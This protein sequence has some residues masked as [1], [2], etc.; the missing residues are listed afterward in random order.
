[1]TADLDRFRANRGSRLARI[2]PRGSA[3]STWMTL[4]HPL[5]CAIEGT[6][7]F[8][9]LLSDISENAEL[10][11]RHIKDELTENPAI[12]GAYP[13]ACGEGPRWRENE[14]RLRNGVLIQARGRGSNIRG[15][16]QRSARPTLI[17]IDDPQDTPD[18]VSQTE[19][20]RAWEW[21]TRS[22]IPAGEAD[23]TSFLSVGTA[24]HREAIAYRL[25]TTP[26][27]D[28]KVYRSVQSWPARSD[29]WDEWGRKLT[30]FTD[31]GRN[32]TARAFYE[33]N[34]AEMDRGARVLWP[35]GRDL[36]TLMVRRAEIGPSAFDT[37]DQGNPSSGE[38]AVWP[39][40]YFDYP[41]F[42]FDEWPQ[43]L[44]LRVAWYDP[45]GSPGKRAGCYHAL[46]LCGTDP[47]GVLW[48][49][50]HLW[51]GPPSEAVAG[52]DAECRRFNPAVIG[53][54]GNFGGQF[55]VPLFAALYEQQTRGLR[56]EQFPPS[57]P[58]RGIDNTDPKTTRIRWIDPF[59]HRRQV[60]VRATVG[61]KLL[62]DQWRDF[63]T[64]EYV[65]GPD[66]AAGCLW[67]RNY[68]TGGGH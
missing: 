17:V 14:I 16:R 13:E 51:R 27:W 25:L 42:W 58:V 35:E 53:I 43:H 56:P 60:R 40:E 34:R 47:V 61:G 44:G 3:K 55:L 9:I 2:A 24:L 21:V 5:R 22:V 4:A 11:L 68:L 63:D 15:R 10:Y 8:I 18:I 67:L 46:V 52:V 7:P 1:L 65:D 41:G 29:L 37:E 59:L 31:P 26:G 57:L 64:G 36:Y 49:D 62:V 28:G 66:A 54:E 33:A 23:T 50:A 19:R 38:L 39:A 32:E 45:A 12:E 6:E 20:R 48:F 30:N